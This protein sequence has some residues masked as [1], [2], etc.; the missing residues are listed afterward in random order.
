MRAGIGGRKG[1]VRLRKHFDR[2]PDKK[3][4]ELSALLLR[5]LGIML[6]GHIVVCSFGALGR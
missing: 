6:V 5:I 4:I 1:V 3:C 2:S